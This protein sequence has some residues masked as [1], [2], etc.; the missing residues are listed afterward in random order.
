MDLLV[1]LLHVDQSQLLPLIFADKLTQTLAVF[2][3]V[4]ALHKLIRERLDPVNVFL[5]DLE[6]RVADLSLPLC[7]DVDVWRVLSDCLGSVLLHV[8]K[9]FELLFVLLVD[10]L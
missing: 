2:D 4:E 5:F 7:N 9:L 3:F 8:L 1:S 6:E 10:I